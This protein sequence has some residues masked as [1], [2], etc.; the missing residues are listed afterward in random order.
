MT[1][2]KSTTK[3][4]STPKPANNPSEGARSPDIGQPTRMTRAELSLCRWPTRLQSGSGYGFAI[5]RL[6]QAVYGI[7]VGSKSAVFVAQSKYASDGPKP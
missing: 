1:S 6:A 5:V 2:D 4:D 3:S 7:T